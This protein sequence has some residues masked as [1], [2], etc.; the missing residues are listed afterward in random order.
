MTK[1]ENLVSLWKRKSYKEAPVNFAL[2][3]SAYEVFKEKTGHEDYAEYFGFPLRWIEDSK[4]FDTDTGKFKAYYDFEL[5]PGTVIDLWGIAHEPGSLDA[6]HMTRMRHP[7]AGI[8]SLQQLMEYPFPDFSNADTNHQKKQVEEIHTRGLAAIGGMAC[9]IWE[10]SWY[11]RSMEELMMDMKTEDEKAVYLL[12]KVTENACCRASAYAK[13]GVDVIQMGDDIGMQNSIMMSKEMYRTW[14]KPR[15]SKVINAAREINPDII[16]HYHT[17]GYVTPL[18]NDLIEAGI[19]VLNPVQPE[20][21][22][23]K[24]IHAEF[25]DRLS[26]DGTIGTQ[27][28]MPF[29]TPEDVRREVHKNLEI[30]GNKGGLFCTPTHLLEP[31]VPWENIVAYVDACKEFVK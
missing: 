12:D 29:G 15:L 13:A 6:K 5:K 14:L 11:M 22:S 28:T 18:I 26:F 19:D 2:C 20:C 7:M 25:S 23:F 9:T 30:A 27:T 21:M 31:E 10:T 4:P 24:E 17:C 16:I 8:D 1:R 3:P